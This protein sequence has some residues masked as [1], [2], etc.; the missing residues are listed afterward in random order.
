MLEACV[1][2]TS[3]LQAPQPAYGTWSP[4]FLGQPICSNWVWQ[5]VADPWLLARANNRSRIPMWPHITGRRRMGMGCC[6]EQVGPYLTA[7]PHVDEGAD[8]VAGT[9]PAGQQVCSV[10]G[11]QQADV[12]G[13]VGLGTGRE[14]GRWWGPC[15]RAGAASGGLHQ[16]RTPA[17]C[18]RNGLLAAPSL[19]LSLLVLSEGE[20]TKGGNVGDGDPWRPLAASGHRAPL[21]APWLPPGPTSG[22]SPLPWRP[23]GMTS[24]GTSSPS[25][26]IEKS[27]PAPQPYPLCP[28]ARCTPHPLP[29]LPVLRDRLWD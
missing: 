2:F 26:A 11:L 4:R 8:G 29:N 28:P 23:V 21:T 10:V 14:G 6:H 19:I 24:L 9:R 15:G 1:G 7:V 13:T 27:S 20:E 22:D 17:H 18:K 5:G 25:P 12:V 16:L 3:G